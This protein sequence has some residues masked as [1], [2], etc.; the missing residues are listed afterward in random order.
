MPPVPKKEDENGYGPA[1]KS[2]VP[3][4][5]YGNVEGALSGKTLF[6]SAGHGWTYHTSNSKW[7]TQRDV[8]QG[9][10]E[11]DSNA[12]MVSYFLIPY[13]QNAGAAVFSARER[14]RQENMVII[15]PVPDAD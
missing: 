12:E 5:K 4:K 13:L 9:M 8:S 3:Q 1:K 6:V 15:D 7:A 2:L 10:R 11:D 14:D